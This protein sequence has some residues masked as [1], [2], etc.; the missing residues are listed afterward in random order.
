MRFPKYR[1]L[2]SACLPIA[3]AI[4]SCS[5]PTPSQPAATPAAAPAQSPAARGKVLV[6]VGGCHDC[7]TTK[8]AGAP[9]MS[10]ML[11]GAPAS[12]KV[13]SAPKVAA[14]SPWIIQTTDTLTAWSGPW[15]TSFAANLTP[16][17]DTGLKSS[18]WSE[19]AF[20]K[21]MK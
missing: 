4:S 11:S 7:H 12:I 5:Q 18:A 21:A 15:G 1:A 9:D 20:L 2:L 14:N 13:P 8:K 17:P 6:Q 19:D 3:V 10:V 16:D